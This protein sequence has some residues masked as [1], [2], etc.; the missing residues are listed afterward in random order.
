MRDQESQAMAADGYLLL[1]T[2]GCRLGQHMGTK[3]PVSP[4][5]RNG[6]I[7]KCLAELDKYAIPPLQNTANSSWDRPSCWNDYV[8]AIR[9]RAP[10]H[11]NVIISNENSVMVRQQNHARE[12]SFLDLIL[13][14]LQDEFDKV[15]VVA[16]YRHYFDWIISFYNQEFKGRWT[17]PRR[18]GVW[19]SESKRAII[20]P[21][22]IE[23][24]L[25]KITTGQRG[26]LD[27]WISLYT[28]K[29]YRGRL[30]FTIVDMNRNHRDDD[31][32]ESDYNASFKN[33]SVSLETDFFC[34]AVPNMPNM[35]RHVSL[36]RGPTKNPSRED[37]ITFDRLATAAHARGWIRP[38]SIS[39]DK[40]FHAARAFH[41]SL[42]QTNTTTDL[43][44]LCPS[45]D[46]LQL[47]WTRSLEYARNIFA[48]IP[49]LPSN[50]FDI[51]RYVYKGWN[52]T[53]QKQSLCDV[54]VDRVLSEQS[55][56][57]LFFK[58]IDSTQ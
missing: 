9:Q 16:T 50:N 39:R 1:E 24:A 30:E 14:D 8:Q 45:L 7:P 42:T 2:E 12:P 23:Y 52:R 15:Q 47:L 13:Q 20:I 40:V 35:C 27:S 37:M 41:S 32:D 33:K 53:L 21:R 19:P 56:W 17:K 5:S 55:H 54:D 58:G 18:F 4:F 3:L 38:S 11:S 26:E 49:T 46:Q 31:D 48:A 44:R 10:E 22:K 25:E 34:L 29:R 36:P 43:A 28:S 57:E 51:E 6:Y